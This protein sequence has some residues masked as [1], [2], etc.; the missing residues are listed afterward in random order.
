MGSMGVGVMK[1]TTG[2]VMVE[3][4]CFDREQF[5]KR[6]MIGYYSGTLMN[7]NLC[8]D[9]HIERRYGEGVMSVSV[10]YFQTH[11]MHISDDVKESHGESCHA[12][13]L[14]GKLNALC[15]VNDL[16]TWQEPGI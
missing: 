7:T 10:K 16:G 9:N 11:V 6:V 14:S 8:T 1:Y 2:H 4:G 3:I 12:W 5:G 13:I 15:I